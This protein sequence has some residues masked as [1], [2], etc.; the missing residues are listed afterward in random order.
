MDRR[1]KYTRMVLKEAL[2]NQLKD[3][4]ISK[5]TIKA[6]CEEADI[7]RSTF[8][9][10]FRDVYDLLDQIET[11][12]MNDMEQTL[13]AYYH[14]NINEADEMVIKLLDYIVANQDICL[15]LLNEKV[16][17]G[18]HDKIMSMADDFVVRGFLERNQTD[19]ELAEYLS[20]YVISGSI[21]LIETWLKS[22]SIKSSAEMADIIMRISQNGLSSFKK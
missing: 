12:V 14:V 9:A 13:I 21:R 15:T 8:Y 19:G 6:L 17:A 7:N 22:N 3:K 11:E 20:K 5:I 18:F 2:I 4:S 10:H 16:N 1:K